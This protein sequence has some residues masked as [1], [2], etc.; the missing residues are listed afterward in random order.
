M[1]RSSLCAR[2]LHAELLDRHRPLWRL[3]VIDGLQS[4]QVG[5]YFK[6]QRASGEWLA[7][8]SRIPFAGPRAATSG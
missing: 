2:R 5:Y 4:G 3:H 1:R 6:A 7:R 8:D